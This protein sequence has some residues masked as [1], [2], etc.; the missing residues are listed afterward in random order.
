[1]IAPL[2]IKT[3][4]QEELYTILRI[5]TKQPKGRKSCNKQKNPAKSAGYNILVEDNLLFA[6]SLLHW[7]YTN[8]LTANR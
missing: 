4:N 8:R 5:R 7:V 6:G 3:N 1:M 2:P